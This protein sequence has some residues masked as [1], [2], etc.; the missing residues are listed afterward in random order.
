[1]HK[2]L[3]I[4]GP[5]EVR[6][7]I[8]RAQAN[9][10]IGHRSADFSAL[11]GG[12]I[13]KL[14]KLFGTNRKAFVFTSSATGVMEGAIRNTV[15]RNLIS[16]INGAFSKRWHEI[17][18]R[19]GKEAD[20]MQVEWG[21]AIKPEMVEDAL[22]K[23]HYEAVLVT[24]NE[25]STG[26][27]NPL[28]EIAEILKDHPD[29]LLLVDAVSSLGG[30]P[31][32][33]D[34]WDIDVIFASVQKCFALPPGITVTFVSDRAL[35]KAKKVENRG[36][37]FD[38]LTML[39]YYE[40]RKQTPAT[41]AISLLY[42]LDV[43]LDKMAEEGMEN[44]FRRHREMAEMAREWGRKHFELFAEPGY[45]SLTVTTIKNTRGISVAELNA[46]LAKRG[47]VISN[48]YGKLKEKTFR[49]GHMGDLTREDLSELLKNIN[50]ILELER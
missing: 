25:T 16:F 17:A 39:K 4:P 22:K 33:I 35:E 10:M 29:T 5:T 7:E 3:F 46:E 6:E 2:K 13:E 50:E 41:P 44:R 36:Y 24:H 34:R 23:K 43:Q 14:R 31:I 42:A 21:L 15:N 8:L 47:F 37:Y 1:M 45:E 38:F 49:I 11:Y 9:P 30:A 48:G 26:V 18:L 40:E 20:A 12:V 32:E 28:G 19:N 27:M